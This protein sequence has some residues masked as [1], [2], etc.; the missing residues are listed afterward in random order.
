MTT[1]GI[2]TVKKL[3][4]HAGRYFTYGGFGDYLAAMRARFPRTVLVAHVREMAPPEGH[5]EIPPEQTYRSCTYRQFSLS[6][7]SC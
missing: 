2:F 5:Y 6:S 3:C 4:W 7:G 1:L